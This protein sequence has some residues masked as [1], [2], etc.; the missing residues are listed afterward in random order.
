MPVEVEEV[1][2]RL[3]V[4]QESRA[5][6]SSVPAD[7]SALPPEDKGEIVAAA[8]RDALEALREQEAR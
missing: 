5:A 4:G 7:G 3:A 1:G 6:E 8:V 2:V